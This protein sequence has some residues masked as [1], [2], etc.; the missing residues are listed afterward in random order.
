MEL[1]RNQPEKHS[2]W[3]KFS[4]QGRS[5]KKIPARGK[6]ERKMET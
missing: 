6:P 4:G 5:G 1:E 2:A 3:Q